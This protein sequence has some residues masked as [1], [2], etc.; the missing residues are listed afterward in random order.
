[1]FS[2]ES[3]PDGD[4]AEENPK[5]AHRTQAQQIFDHITYFWNEDDD[6]DTEI[7]KMEGMKLFM[8]L[9]DAPLLGEQHKKALNW[10]KDN[11]PPA[12]ETRDPNPEKKFR[13]NVSIYRHLPGRAAALIEVDHDGTDILPKVMLNGAQ[14]PPTVPD[15]D[16]T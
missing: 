10:L 9:P 8:Y 11:L 7:E 2:Y 14:I 5:S 15:F 3:L 6:L 13:A 1:M 4:E 12:M 16:E